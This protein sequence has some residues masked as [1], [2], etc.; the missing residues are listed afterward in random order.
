MPAGGG[1]VRLLVW[2]TELG[3]VEEQ[4]ECRAVGGGCSVKN[5]L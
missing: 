2:P 5:H 3:E 1:R 4:A